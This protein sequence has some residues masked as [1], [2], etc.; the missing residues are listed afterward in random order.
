VFEVWSEIFSS[1]LTSASGESSG[2]T[3]A[4]KKVR[5]AVS[6]MPLPGRAMRK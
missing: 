2:L 4:M 3:L 1:D 6:P 5:N